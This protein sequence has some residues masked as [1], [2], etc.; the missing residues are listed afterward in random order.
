MY[1]GSGSHLFKTTP[2]GQSGPAA[3][4]ES[5][6]VMTFLT[7]FGVKL[8]LCSSKLVLEVKQLKRYPSHQD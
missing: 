1:E 7:N 4:D 5:M 3:F 2:G 6:L 8:I